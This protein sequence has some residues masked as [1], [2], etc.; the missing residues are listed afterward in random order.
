MGIKNWSLCIKQITNLKIAEY[1][2]KK[3]GIHCG[4]YISTLFV[5]ILSYYKT[6]YIGYVSL[7]LHS[8]LRSSPG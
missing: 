1:F 3:M 4:N 8:L 7:Y 2:L 5:N 6:S